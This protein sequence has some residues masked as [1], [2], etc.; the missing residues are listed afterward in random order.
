[1]RMHMHPHQRRRREPFPSTNFWHWLLDSIVMAAGILGPLCTLPQVIIIYGS[2]EAAG[3]SVFT[4]TL[5]AIL[6]TPWILYGWVHRERPIFYS[7][8]LWCTFNSLVAVG[9]ML[10]GHA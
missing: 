1:M 2:H 9:A 5:Y 3:V 10:Y 7:Y 8:L 4:W 6:D